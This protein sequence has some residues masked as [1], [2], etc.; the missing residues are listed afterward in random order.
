LHGWVSSLYAAREAVGRAAAGVDAR[1]LSLEDAVVSEASRYEA[2][3]TER[4]AAASAALEGL[5]VSVFAAAQQ[6]ESFLSRC[7]AVIAGDEPEPDDA[8]WAALHLALQQHC[9]AV[10]AAYGARPPAPP[11]R[12]LRC[13][14]PSAVILA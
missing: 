5:A 12:V 4:R 7:G 1:Q 13:I 6:T 14:V 8:D 11:A 3:L 2:S 9:G 10:Q